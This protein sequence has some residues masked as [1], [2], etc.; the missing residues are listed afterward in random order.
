MSTR[1]RF[2]NAQKLAVVDE[3]RS[4]RCRRTVAREIEVDE[5][6]IRLWMRNEPQLRMSPPLNISVHQGRSR[7][8]PDL[9]RQVVEEVLLMRGRGL[10]VNT[11]DVVRIALAI[12]PTFKSGNQN[13]LKNWSVRC[14]NFHGIVT[15]CATRVSQTMPAHM[16]SR[17]EEFRNKFTELNTMN[18]YRPEMVIN[19]DQTAI[20]H[21]STRRRTFNQ[22]GSRTV[23]V[24]EN[25][26]ASVRSTA[27]LGVT[28]AGTKLKPLVIFKGKRG[29][30][31]AR[32]IKA[33]RHDLPIQL[34]YA[35]QDNAWADELV[36]LDYARTCLGPYVHEREGRALLILDTYAAHMTARFRSVLAEKNID[37]LYIPGGLTPVL[38]PLD[39]S[40]NKAVKDRIRDAYSRWARNT[41]NSETGLSK[42]SRK[43]IA[44]W[45]LYAWEGI[46]QETILSGFRVAGIL[47]E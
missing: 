20:Y 2:T 27:L 44:E 10:T 37:P 39:I 5:S 16:N 41:F 33:G 18:H 12:E 6:T 25:P 23:R 9:E 26:N 8:N 7:D 34:E 21:G 22:R 3:I 32:Q 14:M 28:L 35:V 47:V 29:A 1:S 43:D 30:T 40:V 17:I 45:L 31:I 11:S 36:M 13:V 46:R 4:G 24:L 42:P 38:Q 15:R 19:I